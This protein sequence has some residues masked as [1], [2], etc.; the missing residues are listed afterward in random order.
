MTQLMLQSLIG[1]L[2]YGS[3]IDITKDPCPNVQW[4][5]SCVVV[6][7]PMTICHY[8]RCVVVVFP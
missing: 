6:I 7:I 8:K 5:G 2:A 4:E 1:K 3:K